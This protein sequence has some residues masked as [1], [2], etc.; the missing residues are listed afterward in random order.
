MLIN[1][2]TVLKAMWSN[3][4]VIANV[5]KEKIFFKQYILKSTSQLVSFIIMFTVEPKK[6]KKK[7]QNTFNYCLTQQERQRSGFLFF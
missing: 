1:S 3:H 2:K 7:T 6:R 5:L 4:G